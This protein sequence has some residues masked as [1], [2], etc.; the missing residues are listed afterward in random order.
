[1][2]LL[3]VPS[4]SPICSAISLYLYPAMYMEKGTLYSGVKELMASEISFAANDPSGVVSPDSCD[5][6]R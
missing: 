2:R 3:T 5:R 6:L 1:M 4:G